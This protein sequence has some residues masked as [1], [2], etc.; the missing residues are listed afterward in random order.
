MKF[1]TLIV[2]L[3]NFYIKESLEKVRDGLFNLKKQPVR[4]IYLSS[5]FHL[6]LRTLDTLELVR[7]ENRF[8]GPCTTVVATTVSRL[9]LIHGF[10]G[11]SPLTARSC[12]TQS[13][14]FS[15]C[16]GRLAFLSNITH[17]HLSS[18]PARAHNGHRVTPPESETLP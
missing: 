6:V 7:I 1:T 15:V 17:N 12:I 4:I 2:Y 8:P 10:T 11:L 13:I 5:F 9:A 3:I 14:H 16:L 18:E